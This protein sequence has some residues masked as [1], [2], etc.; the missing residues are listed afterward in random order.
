MG[1]DAGAGDN[2][3]GVLFGVGDV[4]EE[5]A[6]GVEPPGGILRLRYAGSAYLLE[7]DAGHSLSFPL[8]FFFSFE[9][10][11]ASSITCWAGVRGSL[12]LVG[13]SLDFAACHQPGTPSLAD[14]AGEGGFGRV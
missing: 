12:S 11:L 9:R 3:T 7:A 5:D 14:E 8:S 6:R 4:G 1:C 13:V 10:D 2:L